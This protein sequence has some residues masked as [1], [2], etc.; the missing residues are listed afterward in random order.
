MNALAV[1][2]C[3]WPPACVVMIVTPV[4]NIPSVRRNSSA[5]SSPSRSISSASGISSRNDC[6]S[7]SANGLEIGMSNSLG[8]ACGSGCTSSVSRV[9]AGTPRAA[10]PLRRSLVS[11]TSKSEPWTPWSEWSWSFDH[12]AFGTPEMYQLEPLSA[13]IIP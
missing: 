12:R 1:I 11:T 4:G 6:P 9:L 5:G 8:G 13:T 3:A 10:Q 7:P 2:P